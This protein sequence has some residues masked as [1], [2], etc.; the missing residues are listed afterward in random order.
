MKP[1]P[2]PV[3][4]QF[5]GD[6]RRAFAERFDRGPIENVESMTRFARTRAAYVA[7]TSMFGY[8]KTRMGTSFQRHFEDDEFSA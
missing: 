6:L 3:F 4:R 7:Q 8:L 1:F 5:A 2:A